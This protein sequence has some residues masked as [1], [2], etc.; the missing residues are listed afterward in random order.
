MRILVDTNVLFSSLLWPGSKPF[1]SLVDV[2]EN[3]ELVL[4]EQNITELKQIIA[5]KAPEHVK[6]VDSFLKA[7]NYV[8]IHP[9]DDVSTD[10]RDKTD[11]P[12]LIAAILNNV[13]VIITGDRDFLS[14]TMKRPI[15]V[16]P[17]D[18]LDQIAI[19]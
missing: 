4:T 18:Y 16:N 12:I 15:C 10:I 11:S 8:L 14:L 7:L 17:A 1:L 6:E 2:M 5:R 13:D 19:H 9:S 3:H